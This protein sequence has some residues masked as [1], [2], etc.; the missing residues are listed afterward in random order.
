MDICRSVPIDLDA[1][2]IGY[3]LIA[4][5]EMLCLEVAARSSVRADHRLGVVRSGVV[6]NLSLLALFALG[7]SAMAWLPC[8]VFPLAAAVLTVLGML[9]ATFVWA[10]RFVVGLI[11]S[12]GWVQERF[13]RPID[14][15]VVERVSGGVA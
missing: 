9:C 13:F 15:I 5:F 1:L 12:V 8:Q 7:F 14:E 6:L 3:W 11:V 4:C 10:Y 2:L